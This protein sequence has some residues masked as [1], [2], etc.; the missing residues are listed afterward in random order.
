MKK[1]INKISVSPQNK[2]D[3]RKRTDNLDT[4]VSFVIKFI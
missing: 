1:N 2:D 3:S 4:K